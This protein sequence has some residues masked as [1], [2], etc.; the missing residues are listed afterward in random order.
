MKSLRILI[1]QDCGVK[2]WTLMAQVKRSSSCT[3]NN[4]GMHLKA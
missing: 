3:F 4:I 2:S 1:K